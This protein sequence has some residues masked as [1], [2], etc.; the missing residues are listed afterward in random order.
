MK[1]CILSAI[2]G[3]VMMFVL[4]A[5]IANI[6]TTKASQQEEYEH[7]DYISNITEAE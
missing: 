5:V 3:A 7:I 6:R 2:A 1:K 4:L